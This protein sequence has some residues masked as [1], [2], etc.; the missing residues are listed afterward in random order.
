VMFVPLPSDLIL[1]ALMKQN[2]WQD[3]GKWLR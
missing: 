1:K 3:K 2:Y